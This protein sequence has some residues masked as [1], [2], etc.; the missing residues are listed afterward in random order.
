MKD[1]TH[2]EQ[3]EFDG[4][5]SEEPG[6]SEIQ[7]WLT[8]H[9]GRFN[10]PPGTRNPVLV[11]NRFGLLE[12]RSMRWGLRRRYR[13]PGSPTPHNARAETIDERPLFRDLIH[14]RRCLV[15][16]SGYY[17][18]VTKNGKKVPYVIRPSD[19]PMFAFG[20]IYDAWIDNHGYVQESFCVIKT[21]PAPSIAAIH[22]RMPV[23]IS[24]EDQKTWLDRGVTDFSKIW[25]LLQPFPDHRIRAYRVSDMVNDTR[26]DSPEL[27]KPRDPTKPE[28]GTLPLPGFDEDDDV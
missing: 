19:G 14:S 3:F 18:W 4:D 6:K 28:T 11:M 16:S 2:G 12:G 27:L 15:P 7:E 21:T 24:E 23:I 10:I 5:A 1:S 25:P 9:A 8:N 20:A 26:N 17:E 13:K 22:P